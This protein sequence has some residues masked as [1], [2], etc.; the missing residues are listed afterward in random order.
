MKIKEI[1]ETIKYIKSS[2]I[3]DFKTEY[4]RAPTNNI[5][6][7][8]HLKEIYKNGMEDSILENLDLDDI[9]YPKEL[10]KTL[11]VS[12]IYNSN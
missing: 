4:K 10:Y 5:E 9:Q 6:L 8:D 7:L 1:I 11:I 12:C 3:E 2:V